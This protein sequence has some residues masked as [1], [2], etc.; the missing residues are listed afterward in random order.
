MVWALSPRHSS[1][2]K[3][4]NTY[5]FMASVFWVSLVA[6]NHLDV[7]VQLAVGSGML[8]DRGAVRR[9]VSGTCAVGHVAAIDAHLG[10]I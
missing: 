1:K 6:V 9:H 8:A 2:L 3:I 10:V 7:D 4:V 5:R